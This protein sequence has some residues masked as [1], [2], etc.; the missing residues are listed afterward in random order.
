MRRKK[1]DGRIVVE[2][3]LCTVSVMDVPIDDRD[4]LDLRIFPLRVTRGDGDVV[5]KAKPHRP[6]FRRM[7]SWRTHR[8]ESILYLAAHDQIDGLARRACSAFRRV[9]RTHRDDGVGVEIADRKST[10]L[11]SSHGYISYA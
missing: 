9:E 7:V 8:H 1:I 2:D 4:L 3:S 11:N 6:F 5:E 10:R